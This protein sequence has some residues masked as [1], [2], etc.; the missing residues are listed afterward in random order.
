MSKKINKSR[1]ALLGMLSMRPASG[2]GIKKFADQSLKHFWAENYGQIYPVLRQLLE[3][4]L[5]NMEVQLQEKRPNRKVYSI[6]EK[7]R[8]ELNAWLMEENTFSQS[9]RNEF[10]LRIFFGAWASPEWICKELTRFAQLEEEKLLTFHSIEQVLQK[11]ASHNPHLPYWMLTLNY[12]Q[13]IS[14]A[15]IKFCAQALENLNRASP[16]SDGKKKRPR[17]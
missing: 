8:A 13:E 9:L 4:E 17:R 5:V 10:L 15:R 7:G 3:E 2:Y 11:D 12:G 16:L 6:T 14:K 1:Y